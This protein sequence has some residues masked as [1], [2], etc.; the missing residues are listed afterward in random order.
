MIFATDSH[1]IMAKWKKHFSQ[2]LN[3]HG[4]NDV[5]QRET[6]TADPLVSEPSVSEVEMAIEELKRHKPPRTDQ[7][8]A[9]F[10]KNRSVE[11]FALR[12]INLLIMF[13]IRRN[14]L[15]SGRMYLLKRRVIK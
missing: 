4:V 10:I 11:K 15:E 13:G 12:T 8:P 14:C 3:V 2:L 5:R 6:H 1:N 7:I 9:E